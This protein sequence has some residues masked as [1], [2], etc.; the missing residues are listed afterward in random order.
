M[1]KQ[2]HAMQSDERLENWCQLCNSKLADT[3]MNFHGF[4]VKCC[5]DCKEKEEKDPTF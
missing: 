3:E 5:H 2:S 1:D 4:G